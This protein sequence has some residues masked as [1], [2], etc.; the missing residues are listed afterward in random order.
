MRRLRRAAGRLR[1]RA[2]RVLRGTRAPAGPRPTPPS[3]SGRRPVVGIAG[4]YGHGN[5]GDEL[6]LEVFEQHLGPHVDLKVLA[7]LPDAPYYSRP[8]RDLVAEVDAIVIGG[9][10]ILQPSN[11]DPRYFNH[12]FLAKPVFVAGVGVP[13]Y[14]AADA[15][16]EKAEIVERHRAFLSHPNVRRIGVRD[17]SAARWVREKLD[18]PLEVLVAPD[19]VCSLDLPEATKPAGAPVLGVV[20][21]FRPKLA[22][23]DDYTQL[24]RLAQHAL[25][26]GWRV[27]HIILGTGDVG[28]RDLENAEDFHLPGKEVVHS[29]DLDDLSRAI[30]GCTALASMKFHGTVVAT[31]YG[32]PSIVLVPTLKNR[33]FMG[34]IGLGALVS[35]FDSPRLVEVFT[36]RPEVRDEDVARIR[37]AAT[38][39]MAGLAH[40]I[41]EAV[42]VR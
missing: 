9:G 31:M 34:R 14:A 29:E 21:R 6:F 28:R 37:D 32:V 8:V 16:Q 3:V 23:P 19:I 18:P 2:R 41:L 15:P 30:G 22:A 13:R 5:Y 12:E 33:T 26:Q 40:A 11:Q 10:D 17:D 4:F 20:T 39:H 27:R 42:V 7:D 1:R 38:E 24:E 36:E 35:S 25:D